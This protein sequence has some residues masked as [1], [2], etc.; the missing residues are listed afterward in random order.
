M[1]ATSSFVNLRCIPIRHLNTEKHTQYQQHEFDGD[2]GSVL[3]FQMLCEAA[4][5]HRAFS[6]SIMSRSSL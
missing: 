2:R 5:D 6:F 3:F 1:G 4:E